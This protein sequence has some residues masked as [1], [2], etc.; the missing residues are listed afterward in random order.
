M[1]RPK[2]TSRLGS[3]PSQTHSEKG[4]KTRA[5][6]LKSGDFQVGFHDFY[7]CLQQDFLVNLWSIWLFIFVQVVLQVGISP[8]LTAVSRPPRR[9]RKARTGARCRELPSP[10][11]QSE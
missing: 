1:K 5:K 2:L 8:G 4:R 7:D 10:G 6:N 11:A 3:S 9:C